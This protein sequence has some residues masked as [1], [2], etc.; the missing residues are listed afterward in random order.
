M[1]KEVW[2]FELKSRLHIVLVTFNQAL[3]DL[4]FLKEKMRESLS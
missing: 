1:N 4:L 2:G 3:I